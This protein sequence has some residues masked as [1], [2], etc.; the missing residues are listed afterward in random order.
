MKTHQNRFEA[1]ECFRSEVTDAILR[2]FEGGVILCDTETQDIKYMSNHAKDLLGI[3]KRSECLHLEEL[4]DERELERVLSNQINGLS[5]KGKRLG[6]ETVICDSLMAIAIKDNSKLSYFEEEIDDLHSLIANIQSMYEQYSDDTICI[7]DNAGL[8]EYAGEACFRHCGITS[9]DIVGMNMY[10]LEKKKAFYPAVTCKVL[11][12]GKNEVVMQDTQVGVTLITIGVPI[13]DDNGNIRKVISISRDFSRELEMASLLIKAKR[14]TEQIEEEATSNDTIISCSRKIHNI[15]T[16]MNIV[17][18][19]T[20]TVLIEGETGTG[21]TI[22]A[23]YIHE[24]SKGS[25][26]PYILV[27]CGAIAENIIESELFGYEPGTFTGGS[28]EGKMGL[29]EMANGGTLVLD[30]VSELPLSQQVKL[31]HVLQEKMM[32]RMGGRDYIH[33]NFRVIAI[34]NKSL[35]KLVRDGLFREDLYYRLNVVNI[36]VPPL[37]ERK[38]DI[39]MLITHFL[40]RLN[41]D[42]ST[43][44]EITDEAIRAM[45]NC[46]WPGNVRELENI[47]EMLYIVTK[48]D[49]IESKN[50]PGQLMGESQN[51][52]LTGG[53]IVVNQVIELR[54]AIEETERQ[55]MTMAYEEFDGNQQKI[56]EKLSVDRST[57]SRKLKYYGLT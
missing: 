1:L 17:A 27:N 51:D 20:S 10:D 42:N 2:Y 9:R 52:N 35:S 33:L 16:L 49:L 5:R 50:L 38:E 4:F 39:P 57:I 8:V 41:R 43:H 34:S 28:K 31:L 53:S 48:G 12:S 26:G 22:F 11:A 19:T 21:K 6:T 37:R 18:R 13:F 14:E 47:V 3:D 24:N 56:A 32:M 15:I 54:R 40:N 44:K 30:E 25:Q 55:L 7:A 23:K 36:S 45:A 29:L 46:S